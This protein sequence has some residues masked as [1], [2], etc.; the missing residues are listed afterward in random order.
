MHS[1]A[2]TR[3]T[4]RRFRRSR[5]LSLYL[6]PAATLSIVA[7]ATYG[8][9][10]YRIMHPEVPAEA[11]IPDPHLLPTQEIHWTSQDGTPA[12]GWFIPGKGAAPLVVLCPGYGSNRTAVLNLASTLREAGY[13]LLVV[14]LRGHGMS[15]A[16]S[17]LGWKEAEDLN[18]GIAAVMER[19]KVDAVRVGV[20]GASSGAFAALRAAQQSGKIVAMALDAV[21][22]NLEHFAGLKAQDLLGFNAGW[23][24]RLIGYGLSWMLGVPEADLRRDIPV[25][26]M[27]RV[28]SLFVYGL[29]DAGLDEET[30]RLYTLAQGQKHLIVV[31]SGRSA[32]LTGNEVKNYDSKILEFFQTALPI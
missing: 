32:I 5:F 20:W 23:L 10:V 19:E 14:A 6:W 31:A 4:G 9:L 26:G 1:K 22:G 28:S 2:N 24:R 27:S 15:P 16:A 30:R 21:Y 18:S 29:G 17:T 3:W 7:L 8:W 11:R 12:S 25:Q 13:N